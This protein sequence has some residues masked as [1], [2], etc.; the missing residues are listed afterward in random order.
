MERKIRISWMDLIFIIFFSWL[1]SACFM[2][3]RAKHIEV[4]QW[5]VLWS[6]ICEYVQQTLDEV[7]T[8]VETIGSGGVFRMQGFEYENKVN[9]NVTIQ[10]PL[11]YSF[12]M[13]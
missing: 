12:D 8:E 5:K 13:E 7:F 1:L 10:K 2:L 3:I 11:E 4:T 9:V 6:A